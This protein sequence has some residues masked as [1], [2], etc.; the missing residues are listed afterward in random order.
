M[1]GTAGR[2]WRYGLGVG[3]VM[4]QECVSDEM[5]GVNNGKVLAFGGVDFQIPIFGPAGGAV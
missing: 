2:E 1:V 5:E 4:G 3:S